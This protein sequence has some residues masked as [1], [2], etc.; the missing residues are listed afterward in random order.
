MNKL[1]YL[2]PPPSAY[3]L[4]HEEIDIKWDKGDG[5]FLRRIFNKVPYAEYEI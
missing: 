5:K 3:K 2:A 4:F 1:D